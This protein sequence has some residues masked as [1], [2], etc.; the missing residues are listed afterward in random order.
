MP[1]RTVL[2]WPRIA[3]GPLLERAQGCLLGQ[4]A[5]DSLGSRVAGRTPAEIGDLFPQGVRQLADGGRWDIMAG[6]P[7]NTSELALALARSLVEVGDFDAE[8]V[9]TA[10]GAWYASHPFDLGATT[11][12]ALAPASRAAR[13]RAE[14]ASSKADRHSQSNGSLMRVSPIGI[15][16]DSVEQA[17]ACAMADSDLTHPHP[18]CAIACGAYAGAIAAGIGGADPA[19]MLRAAQGIAEDGAGQDDGVV[20]RAL[21]AAAAGQK[22]GDYVRR[23]GWVVVALQNAFFHLL[24]TAGLADALAATISEGGDTDTNAAV[25]GAL[26]GACLG[27]SAIPPQW[28]RAIL[29]CRPDPGL[30]AKKPR[31]A[32]Y[33]PDDALD[34]AEA[35]LACQPRDLVL[36]VVPAA[37]AIN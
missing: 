31:P 14:V 8:S 3:Q 13:A 17:A 9:A 1:P 34:L 19:G 29:S 37:A 15:W 23:M 20:M 6:Q 30:G 4:L 16:A 10:Y 22:P 24:H 21:E 35:L 11:R 7:T 32:I 5:G 27:R 18:V 25:T 12:I 28:S 36:S 2:T 33:W 26:L